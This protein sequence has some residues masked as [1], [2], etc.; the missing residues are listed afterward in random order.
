MKMLKKLGDREFSRE[1]TQEPT[2]GRPRGVLL[3]S[4]AKISRPWFQG[5]AVTWISVVNVALRKVQFLFLVLA[6]AFL[7]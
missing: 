2:P 4:R 1:G 3:A 7:R 6:I 5:A